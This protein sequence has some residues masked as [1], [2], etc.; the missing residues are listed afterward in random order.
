MDL[1]G[2]PDRIRSERLR[3][4]DLKNQYTAYDGSGSSGGYAPASVPDPSSSSAREFHSSSSSRDWDRPQR[5]VPA[6]GGYVGDEWSAGYDRSPSPPAVLP[7]AVGG[8][9]G[10]G[11]NLST[12]SDKIDFDSGREGYSGRLS[13]YQEQE[14][15]E[16]AAQAEG[17]RRCVRV[18]V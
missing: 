17:E 11:R 10:H 3:A 5:D 14:R 6:S 4:R 9:R 1:L 2:N 18:C 13:Q 12:G 7:R 15:R 8:A 16:A